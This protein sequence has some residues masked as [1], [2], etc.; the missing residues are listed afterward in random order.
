MAMPVVGPP[1]PEEA[2]IADTSLLTDADAAA[3]QANSSSRTVAIRRR[4]KAT[5][6]RG[7]SA[8]DCARRGPSGVTY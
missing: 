2:T 5:S 7:A 1:N 3:G 6:I 8:G 4:V